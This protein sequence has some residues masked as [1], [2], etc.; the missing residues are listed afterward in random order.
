MKT[1]PLDWLYTVDGKGIVV[2]SC[3]SG[4]LVQDNKVV[5]PPEIVKALDRLA[6]DIERNVR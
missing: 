5:G 3:V 6:D 4:L 1:L 2:W